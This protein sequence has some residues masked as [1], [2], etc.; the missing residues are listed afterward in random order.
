MTRPD[1][2]VTLGST[3]GVVA[4]AGVVQAALGGSHLVAAG[5][6]GGLMLAASAVSLTLGRLILRTGGKS[7]PV[8]A[9]AVAVGVRGLFGLGGGAVVHTAKVVPGPEAVFWGWLLAAYLTALAVETALQ[10]RRSRA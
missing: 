10:V 4:L 3:A 2:A 8:V 7:G 9:Y 6:A 1:A 5:V